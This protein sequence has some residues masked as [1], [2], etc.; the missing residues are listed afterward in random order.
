[1]FRFGMRWLVVSGF[2]SAA[3][4]EVHAQTLY[5]ENG[6]EVRASARIIEYGAERCQVL[7]EHESAAS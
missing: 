3:A 6:I 4:A 7:E 1:M 2:L 5:S